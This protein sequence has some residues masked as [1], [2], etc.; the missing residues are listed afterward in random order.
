[1]LGNIEDISE[2]GVRDVV[3]VRSGMVDGFAGQEKGKEKKSNQSSKTQIHSEA[4]N[5]L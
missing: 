5:E 3:C 4:Q 1:M 2:S